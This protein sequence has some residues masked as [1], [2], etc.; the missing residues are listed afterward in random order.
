MKA[1]LLGVITMGLI[2][3]TKEDPA[4]PFTNL[5][6]ASVPAIDSA[7]PAKTETATFALG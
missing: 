2:V 4:L 5:Q 6:S 1:P 7:A 3:F